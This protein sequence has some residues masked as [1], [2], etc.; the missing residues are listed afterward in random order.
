MIIP[1]KS[2]ECTAVFFFPNAIH[3][4]LQSP[5]FITILSFFPVEQGV[6]RAYAGV[7]EIGEGY[8]SVMFYR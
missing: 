2:I 5:L 8:A 6:V 7:C 3:C 1:F 4:N